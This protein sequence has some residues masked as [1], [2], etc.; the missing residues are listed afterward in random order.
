MSEKKA[1]APKVVDSKIVSYK[2]KSADEP[3]PAESPKPQ[4]GPKPVEMNEAVSR[5]E[6]LLGTTYRMKP[7]VVE[8]AMYITINNVILNEGTEHETVRPYEIFINSRDVQHQQWVN[9]LTLILS[10]IFRKGGD[11]AF[12]AEELRSVYD[13]NGGYFKKGGVYMNSI[14]AEIGYIIEQHFKAIGLIEGQEMSA[15][16]KAMLAEK[17]A[18]AEGSDENDASEDDGGYPP[19]ATVCAKCHTKAVIMVNGCNS[20]LSCGDSK[21]G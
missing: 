7:P 19:N 16:M 12:L 17:R 14:V 4:S 10:A 15:E 8:N 3:V 6:F 2:I 20:C 11:T 13:P 18:Q 21:C 9:A 1:S 5:P